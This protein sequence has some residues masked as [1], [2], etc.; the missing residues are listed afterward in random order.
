MRHLLVACLIALCFGC[1]IYLVITLTKTEANAFEM[2]ALPLA[3]VPHIAEILERRHARQSLQPGRKTSVATLQGYTLQWLLMT[4]LG[5]AIT[6]G[7]AQVGS[8][9]G[10]L[11]AIIL[12]PELTA[13]AAEH[14]TPEFSGA[15]LLLS[16]IAN[17]IG[18]VF[19]ARWIGIRA[20]SHGMLAV[21]LMVILSQVLTRGLDL[22][23]VPI[24]DYERIL[25]AT[26]VGDILLQN[27]IGT[28]ILCLLGLF[29]YWLGRRRRLAKYMGYLLGIL[30]T[31]TRELLVGLA[32]E[33][34]QAVGSGGRIVPVSVAAPTL[35]VQ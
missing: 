1:G 34:A 11:F 3:A 15:V 8:L 19:V 28:A 22:L 24:E 35:A 31:E 6:F 10:G 23:M 9:V 13:E 17:I 4:V 25:G 30:P 5:A 20:R 27:C 32:Y 7:A 21:I 2:S 16:A 26:G 14:L 29:G 33:E 18:V 12:A